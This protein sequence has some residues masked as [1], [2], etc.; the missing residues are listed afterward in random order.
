MLLKANLDAGMLRPAIYAGPVV[1]FE[2]SCDLAVSGVP[3]VSCDDDEDGFDSRKTTEWGID[4]GANLDV[5][6]G[7]IMLVADIRYQLGLTNLSEFPDE[8]FKTR[9]WQLMA[10]IGFSL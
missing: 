3:T 6:L 2:T 7:P 9:M 10:G 4:F 8:E 1:S 5:F